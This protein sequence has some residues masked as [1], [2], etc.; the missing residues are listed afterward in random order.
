V[1]I[2]VKNMVT[3]PD[4]SWSSL[5]GYNAGGWV[6]TSQKRAHEQSLNLETMPGSSAIS[7]FSIDYEPG[8]FD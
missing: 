6:R 5:R 8:S 2:S 1:G 3:M 4:D 7:G